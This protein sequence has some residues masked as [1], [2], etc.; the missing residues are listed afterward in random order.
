SVVRGSGAIAVLDLNGGILRAN[1]DQTN[2]LNGFTALTVG[3]E[4]AWFDT[5]THAVTIG[6]DFSGSSRFDKLGLG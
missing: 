5:N 2:F 4:G 1:Q 3:A 6:T